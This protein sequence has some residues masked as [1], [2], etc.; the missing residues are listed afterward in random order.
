MRLIKGIWMTGLALFWLSGF[1][2]A[3]GIPNLNTRTGTGG[4]GLLNTGSGGGGFGGG[5]FGG[6]GSQGGGGFQFQNSSP[7]SVSNVPKIKPDAKLISPLGLFRHADDYKVKAFFPLSEVYKWDELERVEHGFVQNLGQIGKPY[8]IWRDGL[9]ERYSD[10][11]FWWNS[12]MGRYNRY[13]LNPLSQVKYFDTKTPYVNVNYV[14]GQR[15]TQLV[16]VT[17]SQNFGPLWNTTIYLRRRQAIGAY[18]SGVTDH[19]SLYL[20]N[21]YHTRNNRY[22]LFFNVTYNRIS[23]ELNGGVPRDISGNIQE[24]NGV[25]V[26]DVSLFNQSFFKSNRSPHLS[27]AQRGRV[28]RAVYA[29]QY[30]HLFGVDDSV[31]KPHK[32]TLR[33]ALFWETGYQRFVA[34]SLNTSTWA[35]NI[36]PVI[37]HLDPRNTALI[38]TFTNPRFFVLGEASYTLKTQRGFRVHVDGGVNYERVELNNEAAQITQNLTD[39]RVRGEIS[40]PWLTAEATLKQ[41]VSNLLPAARQV[42]IG[43]SLLPFPYAQAYKNRMSRKARKAQENAPEDSVAME[44][45][46]AP[47]VLRID[48]TRSSSD[49]QP[50]RVSVQYDLKDINPTLFQTFYQWPDGSTY[51]AKPDLGNQNLN[52][53]SATLRWEP[54]R[55]ILD[56]DTLLANYYQL[57]GFFSRMGNMIYYTDS[58]EVQQ[59]PEGDILSWVGVEASLRQ[60]FLKRFHFEGKLAWQRATAPSTSFLSLYALSVPDFYGQSALYYESDQVKIADQLRFGV[61][62]SYH[63]PYLGQTVDPS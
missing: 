62:V 54:A 6:G 5:G 10:Q 30:Y 3:Q 55:P 24:V 7:D 15:E 45:L 46:K 16:D 32:L 14:Q 58:M 33:N 60:R 12:A 63:T 40:F 50:L 61:Q 48:S 31:K 49:Y 57:R 42:S 19:T 53:L 34:S 26:D 38:D 56:G 25:L 17:L 29:D 27:T 9:P 23:D 35:N 43:G 41:R 37:P 11:E 59:A 13:L 36:V 51:E 22:H 2:A 18:R 52:H 39:Q 21:N 44:D 28:S 1:M 47:P 4:G 8:M 20:S